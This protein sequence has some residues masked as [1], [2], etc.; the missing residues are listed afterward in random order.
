MEKIRQKES[1]RENMQ[2]YLEDLSEKFTSVGIEARTEMLYGD[3]ASTIIDYVKNTPTQLIALATH[4]QSS[5]SRMIFGSVTE[6]I[7]HLVKKTPILLVKPT[8]EK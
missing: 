3:P 6:N 1:Q 2:K 5:L 4:G 7:I 8:E